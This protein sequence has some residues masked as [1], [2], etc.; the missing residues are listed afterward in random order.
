MKIGAT[1][2]EKEKLEMGWGISLWG[3]M[4]A[5]PPQWQSK[6]IL[7]CKKD[8]PNIYIAIWI[9]KAKILPLGSI[10]PAPDEAHAL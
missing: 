9:V 7:A 10:Y 4:M 8:S 5:I 3:K 2:P 6:K 1:P